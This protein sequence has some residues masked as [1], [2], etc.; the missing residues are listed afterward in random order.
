MNINTTNMIPNNTLSLASNNNQHSPTVHDS[1]TQPPSSYLPMESPRTNILKEEI[2]RKIRLFFTGNE[3]KSIRKSW[4]KKLKKQSFIILK[5]K[6]CFFLGVVNIALTQFILFNYPEYF[7]IYYTVWIIP[8]LI[9]RFFIY[10]SRKWGLFMLDFCYFTNIL[11]L[12]H[13]WIYPSSPYLFETTFILS[14]GPL[15]WA[16]VAWR[17][18]L[19]F[20][21]IDKMTSLFIHVA[22]P[23]VTFS[24]RW[25]YWGARIHRPDILPPYLTCLDPL[26]LNQEKEQVYE[27]IE[28]TIEGLTNTLQYHHPSSI[29]LSNIF[30]T[31]GQYIQ[32]SITLLNQYTGLITFINYLPGIDYIYVL[33]EYISTFLT[34]SMSFGNPFN[35]TLPFSTAIPSTTTATVPPINITVEQLI[36]DIDIASINNIP[37][38]SYVTTCDMSYYRILG[39][40]LFTYIFWQLLYLLYTEISLKS[41]I[42]NNPSE[43]NSLRWMVRAGKGPLHDL[44]LVC[45][46]TIGLIKTEES[47]DSENWRTKLVFI[48]MQLV[49]TILTI[50]PTKYLYESYMVHGI[51]LLVMLA[52]AVWYGANYY[53]DVF[54]KRYFDNLKQSTEQYTKEQEIQVQKVAEQAIDTALQ[55][56]EQNKLTKKSSPL[57]SI[58]MINLHD[59][60]LLHTN[61]LS[62]TSSSLSDS[63]TTDDTE[64]EN[65][66]EEDYEEELLRALRK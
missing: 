11:C 25:Y 65:E 4:L 36:P 33:Y 62:N 32:N 13:L 48:F 43:L 6:L 14:N 56:L 41:F 35:S 5:D 34:T 12:F 1:L 59:K 2:R 66:E 51:F 46:R 28:N 52:S 39:L 58:S 29:S 10:T 49:Y 16:V 30:S 64:E 26:I 50:L 21:D 42:I 45:A 15:I 7:G 63:D 17:N 37:L 3:Q 9:Y 54:A 61:T 47:F 8:L 22:P 38:L 55:K 20:H 44:G 40:P 23:L 24:Q 27:N 31:V 18:S 53:F 19:V 60:S 57:T